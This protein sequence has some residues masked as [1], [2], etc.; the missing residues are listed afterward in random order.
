MTKKAGDQTE[1][2]EL[3]RHR[4]LTEPEARGALTLL[5]LATSFARQTMGGWLTS[6]KK[7]PT[8]DEL[9]NLAMEL[10]SVE[11]SV[12]GLASGPLTDG[13]ALDD[14]I[15]HFVRWREQLNAEGDDAR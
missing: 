9:F 15:E 12:M 4:Q 14:E 1:I 10:D 13:H 6:K 7:R 11:K 3:R 2:T 5:M 8:R